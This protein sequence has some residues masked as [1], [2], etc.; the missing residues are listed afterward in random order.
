MPLRQAYCRDLTDHPA[1]SPLIVH[2]EFEAMEQI[3]CPGRHTPRLYRMPDVPPAQ[4][5]DPFAGIP[6]AYE[7]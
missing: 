4:P 7:D 1:H 2:G 6:G 3:R 5:T